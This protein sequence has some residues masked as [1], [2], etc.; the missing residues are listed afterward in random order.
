[1]CVEFVSVWLVLILSLLNL[2]VELNSVKFGILLN[3]M[4]L[5][6][7]DAVLWRRWNFL[8]FVS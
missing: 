5:Q 8:G 2:L 7:T 4:L 6:V 1:M 3:L